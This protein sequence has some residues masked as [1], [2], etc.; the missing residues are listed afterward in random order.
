MANKTWRTGA[1]IK[2][3]QLLLPTGLFVGQKATL[4]SVEY[5]EARALWKKLLANRLTKADTCKIC[6]SKGSLRTK[7]SSCRHP[8]GNVTVMKCNM[9]GWLMAKVVPYSRFLKAQYFETTPERVDVMSLQKLT[10]ATSQFFTPRWTY[11][12]EIAVPTRRY[13]LDELHA[14]VFNEPI[15]YI[16]PY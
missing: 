7:K 4:Q 2:K 5:N 11:Q 6:Q 14:A 3:G 1:K 16:E 10:K 9:C 15:R 8:Q 13:T 12:T